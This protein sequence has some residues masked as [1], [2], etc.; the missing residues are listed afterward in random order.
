[1]C[2]FKKKKEIVI[3]TFTASEAKEIA[4][5]ALSERVD[6]AI[7]AVSAF[8]VEDIRDYLVPKGKFSHTFDIEGILDGKYITLSD[9]S[10]T[11]VS[12]GVANELKKLGYKV[13]YD[14]SIS[15]IHFLKVV[16]GNE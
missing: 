11:D 15:T 6:E 12:F 14:S 7:V 10:I 3:P 16:W 2:W 4:T 5:K 1:M 9:K 13:F 8:I